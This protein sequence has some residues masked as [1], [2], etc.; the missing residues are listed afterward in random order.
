MLKR[1]T[2]L[3]VAICLTFAS[4]VNA[5]V[6]R[7]KKPRPKQT[8]ATE[9]PTPSE[10]INEPP[11]VMKIHLTGDY[12]FIERAL[13]HWVKNGPVDEA[14]FFVELRQ[15]RIEKKGQ[16]DE[17]KRKLK[18]IGRGV[19]VTGAIEGAIFAATVPL[20][21]E[22]PTKKD[23]IIVV[24]TFGGIGLC[25]GL[26][27]EILALREGYHTEY[28]IQFRYT[29]MFTGREKKT[30]GKKWFWSSQ[31]SDSLIDYV[32]SEVVSYLL[33][34]RNEAT[35]PTL[36]VSYPFNQPI[37]NTTNDALLLSLQASDD[38]ELGRVQ[39][40][41]DGSELASFNCGK[42]KNF[43][44]SVKVPLSIG[45]NKIQVSAK[46]WCD[47]SSNVIET[48]IFRRK[49]QPGEKPEEIASG[50]PTARPK[51]S[52]TVSLLGNQNLWRGG[53]NAGFVV[54]VQNTGQGRGE[55]EVVLSGSEYL[56]KLLG[57][58]IKKLG[59]VGPGQTRSETFSTI[60]PTEPLQQEAELTVEVRENLWG[61]SPANQEKI[62]VALL[63]A[64]KEP[65]PTTIEPVLPSPYLFANRRKN[66]YAVIVGIQDYPSVKKLKYSVRD[67]EIFKEYA[68]GLFGI[69]A[70]NILF[71]KNEEASGNRLKGTITEKL[72]PK[73]PKFIVFYYGGHGV[74]ILNQST[75][76]YE[77]YLVPYDAEVEL[78]STLISQSEVLSLLEDTGADTVVAFFDACFS[79]QGG[80]TP[81]L[82]QKPVVIK[83]EEPQFT[84]SIVFNSSS[85]NQESGEYEMAGQGYFT[86]YLTLG[87]KKYGDTD[88]NNDGWITVGELWN[89][90]N[91]NVP[92]VTNGKQT[93][94]LLAP[95]G[96]M[97]FRLGRWR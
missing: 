84:R 23:R 54:T 86:Y 45:Y 81:E 10:Q 82:A 15:I 52:Y 41:K 69:P 62:R 35:H 21:V 50:S 31:E 18:R 72:R 39:V 94:Q 12:N 87:L 58:R 20:F 43:E 55:A 89:Y 76:K 19:F 49:L 66:G 56:T 26:L 74:P 30:V 88:G 95:G 17:Q 9:Y 75:L 29:D 16:T 4:S 96:A 28:T 47:K 92:R 91:S 70:E 90:L 85:G 64:G 73:N 36:T 78:K 5:Q 83:I 57:G 42:R 97:E 48:T 7:T 1:I 25:V 33:S 93:P 6:G 32:A 63:P 14:D 60:L 11:S 68:A 77:P 34:S 24:A 79:G 80:R 46:D 65:P 40:T 3:V 27:C 44:T 61:E 51:L 2:S 37:Y 53:E 8:K 71:L 59:E 13:P 38:V 22:K 67:A